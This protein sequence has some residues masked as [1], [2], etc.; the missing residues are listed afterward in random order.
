MLLL[1]IVVTL[2][3]LA[4]GRDGRSMAAHVDASGP[5][6]HYTHNEATCAACQARTLQGSMSYTAPALPAFVQHALGVDADIIGAAWTYARRLP[7]PRGPP[8]LT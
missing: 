2:V 5:N 7:R 3:P 1:Q 6:S 8:A 4:E